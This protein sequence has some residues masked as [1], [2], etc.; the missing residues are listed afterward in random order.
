MRGFT[1]IE[2]VIAVGLFATL[3]IAGNLL[4]I[5]T[6]RGAKKAQAV[7]VVRSEGSYALG[8][9]TDLVRYSR[10]VIGCSADGASLTVTDLRGQPATLTCM[11]NG[12][13]AYLASNSARLTSTAVT[14][15]ACTGV[16]SC[17]V[18]VP[19]TR[20]VTI[21]FSLRRS[22]SAGLPLEATADINFT[23]Q[24]QLRND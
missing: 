21:S 7:A 23:S 24:V 16:F 3:A 22:G 2:V 12:S 6:L 10:Q 8:V 11:T 5:G 19:N 18:P 4:L 20:A 14:L 9:I 17:D 15:A 13:D 1:L